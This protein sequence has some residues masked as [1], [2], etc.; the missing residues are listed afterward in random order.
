LSDHNRKWARFFALIMLLVAR[1]ILA[2]SEQESPLPEISKPEGP[3]LEG[4]SNPESQVETSVVGS[5]EENVIDKRREFLGTKYVELTQ[6]IDNFFAGKALEREANTSHLKVV[7][8]ETWYQRSQPVHDVTLKGKLD[9]PGTQKRYRLFLDSNVSEGNSLEERNR[10]VATGER[11]NEETSVAGLE[12][13]KKKSPFQ[14][15]TSF[16]V[17]AKLNNQINTF[18]RVRF[19]KN[20]RLN[21]QWNSFF[22]QDLWYLDGVGWGTTSRS[23][24]TRVMGENTW[25]Q[26]ANEFDVRDERV[27]FE[28]I[29]LW[30]IDQRITDRYGFNYRLGFV[31]ESSEAHLL[32]NR[33]VSFSWRWMMVE[34]W[35]FLHIT[36]EVYFDEE[37][38]YRGEPAITFKLEM[39]L[40]D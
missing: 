29:Q 39:Y 23:E 25:F 3:V 38:N 35:A 30:Q 24:F 34:D 6:V 28:Y 40:T 26:L 16:G 37:E 13:S 20:W 32:D 36:P 1:S 15:K 22:R 4:S 27:A 10:S 9:L 14:W 17:G 33:F 11:V 5:T 31:G 7:T 19:R 2:E 8:Q 18:A 12:F 21:D